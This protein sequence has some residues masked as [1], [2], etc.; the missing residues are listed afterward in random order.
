MS[1]IVGGK[2]QATDLIKQGLETGSCCLHRKIRV[3]IGELGLHTLL[4]FANNVRRPKSV[5]LILS[6]MRYV[7]LLCSVKSKDHGLLSGGTE[8]FGPNLRTS[9]SFRGDREL[10]GGWFEFGACTYGYIHGTF[11][12]PKQ[13]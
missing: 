3:S 12:S 5:V 11:N 9:R 7:V 4:C 1:I 13:I 6:Y 8:C 2:G 10:V